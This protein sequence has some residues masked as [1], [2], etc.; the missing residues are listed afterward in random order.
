MSKGE[1]KSEVGDVYE[2]S[3]SGNDK[4]YLQLVCLDLVNM[5]SDVVIVSN[6]NMLHEQLSSDDVAFYTHTFV[7]DGVEKG[8][9]QKIGKS[10][11]A[12]NIS[13]LLFKTYRDNEVGEAERIALGTEPEMPFPN[14]YIWSPGDADFRIVSEQE[15]DEL[16]AEDG[17]VVPPMQVI[18]RIQDF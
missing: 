18:A 16:L 12:V 11:P 1:L 10:N 9:W 14:W 6:K 8:L 17:A 5:N 3:S 2:I 15:G 13:S 7:D 4:H